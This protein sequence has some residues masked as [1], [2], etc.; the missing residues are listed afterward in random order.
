MLEDKA[1]VIPHDT[2]QKGRE[3]ENRRE[4]KIGKLL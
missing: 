4:K 2:E 3:L 1:E